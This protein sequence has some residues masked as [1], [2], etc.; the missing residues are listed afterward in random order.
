MSLLRVFVQ[1]RL[2]DR[3]FGPQLA[4][5][6]LAALMLLSGCGSDSYTSLHVLRTSAFPANHIP[7]FERT[8]NNPAKVQRLLNALAALPAYPSGIMHCPADFGVVYHLAFQGQ[9]FL[10]GQASI[11]A[12]G[13]QGMSFNGTSRWTHWVAISPR[14]WSLFADTLG[15]PESAV[16]LVVPQPTGPS[17]PTAVP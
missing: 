11:Q 7:P 14:F 9:A 13:C 12:G 15:V 8:V 2:R 6:A 17:A 10:Y 5:P 16:Y 1:Q 3:L 4:I